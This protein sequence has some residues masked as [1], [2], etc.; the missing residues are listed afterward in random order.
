MQCDGCLL[1]RFQRWPMPECVACPVGSMCILWASFFWILLRASIDFV[2]VVQSKCLQFAAY[3]F[4]LGCNVVASFLFVTVGSVW[5]PNTYVP[6]HIFT[7]FF[8]PCSGRVVNHFSSIVLV[9]KKRLQKVVSELT[10]RQRE[11]VVAYSEAACRI[12]E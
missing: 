4:F 6:L 10:P 1:R 11:F 5:F 8:S 3:V 7:R 12:Q 9:K 2:A